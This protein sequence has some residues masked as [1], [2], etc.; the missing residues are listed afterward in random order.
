MLCQPTL[1]TLSIAALKVAPSLVIFVNTN[2]RSRCILFQ[3]TLVFFFQY[4][5]LFPCGHLLANQYPFCVP[6]LENVPLM[7]Q[8]FLP[9]MKF[10]HLDLYLS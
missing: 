1:P 2:G 4:L 10:Y 9:A 8:T 6:N 7:S 5:T 3:G